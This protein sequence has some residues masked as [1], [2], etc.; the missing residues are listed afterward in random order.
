M[1]PTG[2]ETH[3]LRSAL[4][5]LIPL[6][7]S[8]WYSATIEFLADNPAAQSVFRAM[9]VR[10]ASQVLI[11][12][13]QGVRVVRAVALC[14]SIAEVAEHRT[15]LL[16]KSWRFRSALEREIET[17]NGWTFLSFRLAETPVFDCQIEALDPAELRSLALN[18]YLDGGL[19]AMRP[20]NPEGQSSYDLA[21]PGMLVQKENAPLRPKGLAHRRQSH[22]RCEQIVESGLC[23]MGMNCS[24]VLGPLPPP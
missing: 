6:P 14:L 21:W 10:E 4:G 8:A 19:G 11:E 24:V 15:Q 18:L 5:E 3:T 1:D 2:P 9:T 16:V 7:K 20:L 23:D 13:P 22:V 17:V 12:T